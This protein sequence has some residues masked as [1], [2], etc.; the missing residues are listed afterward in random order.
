MGLWGLNKPMAAQGG[1]ACQAGASKSLLAP[2]ACPNQASFL[3]LPLL[4][5]SLS[6]S[7]FGPPLGLT[8]GKGGFEGLRIK[9]SD[10]DPLLQTSPLGEANS[11]APEAGPSS[12][13][14]PASPRPLSSAPRLGYV[15]SSG[16]RVKGSGTRPWGNSDPPSTRFQRNGLQ[17]HDFVGKGWPRPR[18]FAAAPSLPQAQCVFPPHEAARTVTAGL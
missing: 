5:V 17:E 16:W 14:P 15:P 12:P 1:G 11:G 2:P 18:G 9:L 7:P 13:P 4:L 6:L 10:L 3:S 8:R